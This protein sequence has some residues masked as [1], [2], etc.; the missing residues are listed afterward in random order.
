MIGVGA[1]MLALVQARTLG[2]AQVL[3]LAA[4]GIVSLVALFAHERR[5]PEPMLPLAMWRRRVVALCNAAGFGA[6]AA[7]MAVS[8]LLPIFVQGV[9][10]RSPAVA[11]IGRAS[12]RERVCRPGA[13]GRVAW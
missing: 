1:L 8:A 12:C 2:I 7:M 9:M 13:C 11:E 10:G 6:S 5:T 3:A 4:L